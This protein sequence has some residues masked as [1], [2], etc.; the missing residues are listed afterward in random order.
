MGT[1]KPGA[2]YVYES[3]DQ[4]QTIYSRE[5]GT[6]YRTLVGYTYNPEKHKYH[7]EEDQLWYEIR[8]AAKSNPALQ[9]ALEQCKI[10]YHL[11]K[12]EESIFWHPV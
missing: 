3:P 8:I 9:S 11:G 1:L 10:L 6:D 2:T 7:S 4:G 5:V 12:K